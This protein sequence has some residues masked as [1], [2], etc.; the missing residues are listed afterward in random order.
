MTESFLWFNTPP[1]THTHTKLKLFKVKKVL[2]STGVHSVMYLSWK[3]QDLNCDLQYSVN[4]DIT[5]CVCFLVSTCSKK[6]CG[7]F[8]PLA[9]SAISKSKKILNHKIAYKT[10]EQG[11]LHIYLILTHIDI[12]IPIHEY[13]FITHKY[14]KIYLI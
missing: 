10:I 8:S 9:G 1:H 2:H 5:A 4:A 12:H 13:T 11:N 14:T 6:F 7:Q 3:Y